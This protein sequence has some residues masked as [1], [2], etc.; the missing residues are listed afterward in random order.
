VKYLLPLWDDRVDPDF[1]FIAEEY[2]KPRNT[3]SD[4][5]IHEA[6]GEAPFDGILLSRS[7]IDK[8]GS[9]ARRVEK[10]G[11]RGHLRLDDPK[12]E[13]VV[14]MGDCGAFSYIN[15][16]LPPYSPEEIAGFYDSAGFDWGV[17][18]D[19]V[20]VGSIAQLDASGERI[21]VALSRHEQ[22]RRQRVTLDNAERFL[23]TVRCRG[24]AFVP[25]GAVQGWSPRSYCS[26]AQELLDMGYDHIAI[27]GLARRRSS[28]VLQVLEA[29]RAGVRERREDGNVHVHVFGV[30]R[31]DLVSAMARLGVESFDS[32]SA[33]RAAWVDDK[34]NYVTPWGWFPAVRVPQSS[35][36]LMRYKSG[37]VGGLATLEQRCLEAIRG[38]DAGEVPL[39]RV[40]NLLE[41]YDGRFV[42]NG[43]TVWRFRDGYAELLERRPWGSCDCRVCKELGVEVAIFRGTNRNRRRGFHNTWVF[44][45]ELKRQL[46]GGARE[47]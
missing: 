29:V 4:I 40:L 19:H 32:A 6:L 31:L 35:L 45:G 34:K 21:R 38:V 10:L 41:K 7:V 24:Y 42:R 12:W 22:R 15:E 20:I 2:G 13:R 27:G 23:K 37:E 3:D 11:V 33:Y 28:E 25:F 36:R 14:V 8:E 47:A 43:G 18:P 1:D 16:Y 17:A 44:Y 5:F 30:G 39:A 26:A 46:S 9:V